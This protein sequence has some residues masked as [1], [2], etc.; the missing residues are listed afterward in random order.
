MTPTPPP[1]GRRER[2]PL[3]HP[4]LVPDRPRGRKV[5]CVDLVERL[6]DYLDDALDDDERR[7]IDRHLADCED[8]GRV[9]HQWRTVIA[10]SGRLGQEV[11]DQV[12][13]AT[14][15][16]LLAAFRAQPPT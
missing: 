16:Q 1:R 3:G 11:L 12:Q 2:R 10:L 6:T 7:R 9:L 15:D 4:G 14:R 8:C 13:P 5:D